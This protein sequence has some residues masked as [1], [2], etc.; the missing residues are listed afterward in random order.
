MVL[1]K[2]SI[3]T[4]TNNQHNGLSYLNSLRGYMTSF[5]EYWKEKNAKR[6]KSWAAKAKRHAEKHSLLEEIRK[7]VYLPLDFN[8]AFRLDDL[9]LMHFTEQNSL[10]RWDSGEFSFSEAGL[11]SALEA[12]GADMGTFRME[13]ER[14]SIKGKAAPLPEDYFGLNKWDDYRYDKPNKVYDSD[15]FYFDWLQMVYRV[16]TDMEA[17]HLSYG[18]IS[19]TIRRYSNAVRP[20]AYY[21][22]Y[23]CEQLCHSAILLQET[24]FY[25]LDVATLLMDMAGEWDLRHE[26]LNYYAKKLRLRTMEAATMDFIDYTPWNENKVIKKT[27]EYISKG[28]SNGKIGRQLLRP[29][30]IAVKKYFDA[31][32]EMAVKDNVANLAG[33]DNSRSSS[34]TFIE[35][36][37][38]P[39]IEKDGDDLVEIVITNPYD[40]T[41]RVSGSQCRVRSA[42]DGIF[43]YPNTHFEE[44][45]IILSLKT[46]LK[47][48]SEYLKMMPVINPKTDEVI[49]TAMHQYD[50]LVLQG[51][52]YNGN[53]EF[54]DGLAREFDGKPVGK[55][56]KYLKWRVKELSEGSSISGPFPFST[57]KIL[58]DASFSYDYNGQ[59]IERWLDSECHAIYA[60][61]P[62]TADTEARMKALSPVGVLRPD[63]WCTTI[64]KFVFW[65]LNNSNDRVFF[66]IEFID[67]YL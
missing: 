55:M 61:A 26:E 63:L 1:E 54:L 11:R 39:F 66:P 36:V 12:Q 27:K 44:C 10:I 30:I 16:S 7:E 52:K 19:M 67:K 64:E 2:I 51:E 4:N 58:G 22:L 35:S 23:P 62:S 29:W 40:I 42:Y 17:V 60:I 45:V 59:T 13:H 49:V 48:I 56:M 21:E 20:F 9:K 47:A 41:I 24:D 32:T 18:Q 46:P 65:F 53:R 43:F 28:Y 25:T 50:R 3:F 38:C 14:E 34:K 6:R 15:R 37:F 33:F 57:I 31:Q 8:P 5:S